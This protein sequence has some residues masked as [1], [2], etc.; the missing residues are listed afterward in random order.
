MEM[1]RAYFPIL[2]YNYSIFLLQ[3]FLQA[4]LLHQRTVCMEFFSLA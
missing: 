3:T 2:L 1:S 4:R